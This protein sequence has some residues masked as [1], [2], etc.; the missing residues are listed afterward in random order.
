MCEKLEYLCYHVRSGSLFQRSN[1]GDVRSPT[2]QNQPKR[3]SSLRVPLGVRDDG[4]LSVPNAAESSSA[5]SG[6]G[7]PRPPLIVDDGC[8]IPP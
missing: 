4:W 6:P 1:E 8:S 7:L 3:A 2:L 5:S